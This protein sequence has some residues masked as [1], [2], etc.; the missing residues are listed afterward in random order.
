MSIFVDENET[1]PLDVWYTEN[2]DESGRLRSLDVA[3]EPHEGWLHIR[4]HF[5]QPGAEAFGVIL[6]GSTI[7]NHMSFKPLLQTRL[8]RDLVLLKLMRSW[9]TVDDSDE[10]ETPLPHDQKTLAKTHWQITN[11]LFVSYMAETKMEA[12]I[13]VAIEEETSQ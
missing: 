3:T 8:L 7:I 4:G 6:E 10:T 2:R 12:A 13:E 1:F 5:C 9:A 11:H